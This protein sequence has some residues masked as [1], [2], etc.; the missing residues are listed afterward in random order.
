M[1]RLQA[2]QTSSV[3]IV[4]PEHCEVGRMRREERGEGEEGEEE[5]EEKNTQTL[6]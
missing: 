4:G 2:P 6:P 3:A 1:H 5:G